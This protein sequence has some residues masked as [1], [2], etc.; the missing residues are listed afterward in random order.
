MM[1]FSTAVRLV[2]CFGSSV[3]LIRFP[4]LPRPRRFLAFPSEAWLFLKIRLSKTR[5]RRHANEYTAQLE[6]GPLLRLC[7]YL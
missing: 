6:S 4:P 2:L 3:S 1:T 5:Y 7:G